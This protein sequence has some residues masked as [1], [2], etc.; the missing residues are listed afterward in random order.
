VTAQPAAPILGLVLAGGQNER[1]GC[2]K[3]SL[4][5]F[6]QT[7]VAGAVA[8]LE[9]CCDTVVVSIRESQQR[10]APYR[11]CKLV[12]DDGHVRGPGAGLLA[13]WAQW[14]ERALFVLAVDLVLVDASMLARLVEARDPGRLA[15]T[16]RH[17]NAVLEPVCTIWEPPARGP[18]GAVAAKWRSASLRRVLEAGAV[19]AIN[20]DEPWRLASV[21][22]PADL[23]AA[24]QR[25]G[26][27]RGGARDPSG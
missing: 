22:S 13:A 20:A 26:R 9:A 27:G 24:K 17:P 6:G 8:K 11:D 15:T 7:L 12:L 5:L 1:M 4:T 3:G 18:I 16:F 10:L 25:I 19:R 2:D 23:A 14:P 21:N